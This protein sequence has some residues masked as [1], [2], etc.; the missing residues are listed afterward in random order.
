MSDRSDEVTE[1]RDTEDLLEET[2]NLLSGTGGGTETS[3]S[4]TSADA[5]A[6]RSRKAGPNSPTP[7]APRGED[8]ADD[9]SWWSSSAESGEPRSDT[10]AGSSRFGRL[11]SWLSVDSFFSPKAFL[12]LVLLI[13]SG[14]LAGATVLPF[15]GRMIGMFAVAFM[16]GLV[17]SKRRYLEVAA[18]GTSVGAVSAVVGNMFIAVAGSFQTVVA[19]GVAVGL[20]ACLIGYYF[21]R[22]LRDGLSRDIE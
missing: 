12:A 13:G 21:G 6:G 16:I 7:D 20:V 22:D 4:R 2:E 11:K 5:E 8:P 1:S 14:L 3:E 17:T 15:G 9:G 19:V 10:T 18:A